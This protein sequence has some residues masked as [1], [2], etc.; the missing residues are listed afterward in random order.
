ML[1]VT[2]RRKRA[3]H[4]ELNS[5]RAGSGSS[6][7]K[8]GG[9]G[10]EAALRPVRRGSGR[11]HTRAS[12]KGPGHC[13]GRRPAAG[14]S[15]LTKLVRHRW[16]LV[17]QAEKSWTNILLPHS[18]EDNDD[19]RDDDNYSYCRYDSHGKATRLLKRMCFAIHQKLSTN[20]N[21]QGM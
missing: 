8:S 18:N 5:A 10:N 16:P 12:D 9:P 4:P 17:V 15:R 20:F 1:Q 3:A 21:F 13:A 19:Y 11:H 14:L 6:H 2:K 7:S